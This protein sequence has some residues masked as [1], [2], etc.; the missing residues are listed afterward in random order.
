[1]L[2]I[3]LK[4]EEIF[5]VEIRIFI[6][7]NKKKNTFIVYTLKTNRQLCLRTASSLPNIRCSTFNKTSTGFLTLWHIGKAHKSYAAKANLAKDK[8]SNITN[9]PLC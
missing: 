1:M 2:F 4:V 7:K 5:R 3:L 8:A 6:S 9:K